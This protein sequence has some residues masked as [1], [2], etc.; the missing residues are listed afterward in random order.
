MYDGLLDIDLG[1]NFPGY[2]SSSM[3]AFADDVAIIATGR[4]TANLE[5]AMNTELAA[6]ADRMEE[7]GPRLAI[8]KTEAVMLTNKR[9]YVRPSFMINGDFV[10][11]KEQIRYLGVELSRTM[12]FKNHIKTVAA[13][14]E[15][16]AAALAR[17]LPNVGGSRQHSRKILTSVDHSQLLYAAPVWTGSL[18]HEYYVNI[19]ERPQR[20]IGLR[21]AMAYRTVSTQVALVVSGLIPAHLMAIQY[22]IKIFTICKY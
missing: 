11:L 1:G 2:S 12:A 4:D 9:A 15:K 17:I 13:K 7:N 21:V 22:I 20:T 14:A 8:P 18:V 10:Q 5:I 19:L 16:T 3:V 6:V